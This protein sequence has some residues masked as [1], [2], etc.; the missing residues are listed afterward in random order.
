MANTRV[1]RL[2]AGSKA[3]HFACLDSHGQEFHSE[4]LLGR[5]TILFFYPAAFT[6]GCTKELCEFRDAEVSLEQLGYQVIGISSDQ[7]SRVAD[8]AKKNRAHFPMLVDPAKL[9]HK[10]FGIDRSTHLISMIS[11]GRSRSTFVID[12]SGVITHAMY[13]VN[14]MN[15][16]AELQ[17]IL[18]NETHAR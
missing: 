17:A 6:P 8:W 2:T 7:P 9:V 15:H 18:Q 13:N 12:A 5:P 16:V 10:L 3:P 4:D 14:S 11:G 1:T